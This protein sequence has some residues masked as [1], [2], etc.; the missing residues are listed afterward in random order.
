MLFDD[1]SNSANYTHLK[2][3]NSSVSLSK[4]KTTLIWKWHKSAAVQY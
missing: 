4:E 2:T 3:T 1:G